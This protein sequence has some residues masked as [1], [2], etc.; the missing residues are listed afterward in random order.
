MFIGLRNFLYFLCSLSN[1]PEATACLMIG[2]VIFD[3]CDFWE[4]V[5]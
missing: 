4:E 5:K 3:N 1:S 2:L